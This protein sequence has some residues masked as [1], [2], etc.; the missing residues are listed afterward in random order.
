MKNRLIKIEKENIN[1]AWDE[2]APYLLR[3]LINTP[4]YTLEDIRVLLTHGIATLW[5][6]YNDEKKKSFGAMVTEI[7]SHP[8]KKILLIFL[9]SADDFE[10]MSALFVTLVDY[11]KEAGV[12]WI[13]CFGRFGLEK[14][15]ADLGFKKSYIA[16]SFEVN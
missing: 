14:L 16:M 5:M 4:E 13:E 8:Q 3:S 15:L 2:A 11:A 9:M 1:F 10:N 12:D 6:F 7:H